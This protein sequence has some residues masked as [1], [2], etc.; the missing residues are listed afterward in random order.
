MNN[1]ID[2]IVDFACNFFGIKEGKLLSHDTC[3]RCSIARYT[4]WYYIHYEMGVSTRD[5]GEYF[6]RT[7]NTVFK[8]L[9]KLKSGIKTQ[10]Y[11]KRMYKDFVENFSKNNC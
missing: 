11:Y 5:I 6:G 8:G 7:K 10:P 1:D 2:K 4:I 3:D 9:A